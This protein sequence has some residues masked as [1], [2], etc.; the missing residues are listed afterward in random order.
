[1]R[2]LRIAVPDQLML[3]LEDWHAE[4][5]AIWLSLP[6]QNRQAALTQLARLIRGGSLRG[7]PVRAAR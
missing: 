6:E 4:S 2:A 5:A 1:M 7:E 3:S